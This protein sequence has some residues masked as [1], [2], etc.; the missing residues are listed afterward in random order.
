MPLLLS[1]PGT[2]ARIGTESASFELLPIGQHLSAMF[3]RLGTRFPT[4]RFCISH[5][6]LRDFSHWQ[7]LT[8]GKMCVGMARLIYQ[9]CEVIWC[10][11]QSIAIQMVYNLAAFHQVIRMIDIPCVMRPQDAVFFGPELQAFV[12]RKPSHRAKSSV[13][14]FEY[15]FALEIPVIWAS[16]ASARLMMARYFC[17]YIRSSRGVFVSAFSIRYTLSAILC[18]AFWPLIRAGA[19]AIYTWATML[20]ECATYRT[21]VAIHGDS[22]TQ[23]I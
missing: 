17:C 11:I 15:P 14:P 22:I 13:R 6:L 8:A 2:I 23:I 3:A 9:F 19:T 12:G 1:K 7:T 5:T 20:K 16:I 21:D 18:Q 10:V 4:G